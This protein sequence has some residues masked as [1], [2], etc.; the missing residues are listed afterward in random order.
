MYDDLVAK[1]K[2]HYDRNQDVLHHLCDDGL[3]RDKRSDSWRDWETIEESLKQCAG[4]SV[5]HFL[6]YLFEHSLSDKGQANWRT[7]MSAD[8]V[9][10]T[11]VIL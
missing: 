2:L 9:Y 6:A 5:D 8:K 11:E 4:Y 1:L 7:L 3:H 10:S